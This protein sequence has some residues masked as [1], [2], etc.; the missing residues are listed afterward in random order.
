MRMRVACGPGLGCYANRRKNRTSE[1]SWR[2]R[3]KSFAPGGCPCNDTRGREGFNAKGFAERKCIES[4]QCRGRILHDTQP[5]MA[6]HLWLIRVIYGLQ[7]IPA[8]VFPN[9]TADFVQAL[10]GPTVAIDPVAGNEFDHGMVSI[11]LLMAAYFQSEPLACRAA[12][13]VL[14]QIELCRASRRMPGGEQIVIALLHVG[15]VTRAHQCFGIRRRCSGVEGATAACVIHATPA[16]AGRGCAVPISFRHV[17]DDSAPR[18]PGRVLRRAR[19][20]LLR[21]RRQVSRAG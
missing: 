17:R 4:H 9:E 16:R 21:A 2:F 14:F 6:I 18:Y 20:S 5:L 15:T 11:G 13:T 12:F 7:V 8:P 19:A 3:H 10:S 1:R